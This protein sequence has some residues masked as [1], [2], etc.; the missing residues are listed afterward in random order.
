S[1]PGIH[2]RGPA[3]VGCTE[4]GQGQR[5]L[6]GRGEIVTGLPRVIARVLV[7]FVERHAPADLLRPGI[8]LH[9]TTCPANPR[10]HFRRH[11]APRPPAAG[12]RDAPPPARPCARPLL[13]APAGP[14]PPP[15]TPSHRARAAARSPSPAPS[16]AARRA[17]AAA[18]VEPA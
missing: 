17:A 18:R 9:R 4:R 15:A 6:G 8:D 13:R 11:L 10:Q 2:R 7:I 16:A 3:P 5:R 12:A 14:A 1:P